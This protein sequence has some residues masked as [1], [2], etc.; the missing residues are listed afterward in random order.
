MVESTICNA[1]ITA[2]YLWECDT[3]CFV[4]GITAPA[5]GR[6]LTDMDSGMINCSVVIDGDEY[7]S[8]VMFNLQVTQGTKVYII[9]I[10]IH[11]MFTVITCTVCMYKV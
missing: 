8:D 3:G 1:N 4:D 9:C 5:I 11:T 7:M 2:T 6:H 10:Y